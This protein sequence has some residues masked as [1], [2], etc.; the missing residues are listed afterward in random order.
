MFD[1]S[2]PDHINV[3]FRERKGARDAEAMLNPTLPVS[4]QRR[5]GRDARA[6]PLLFG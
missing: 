6:M 4:F 5:G 2:A 3:K 1:N